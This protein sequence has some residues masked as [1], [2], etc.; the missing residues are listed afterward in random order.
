[1]P[2][3]QVPVPP[4]SHIATRQPAHVIAPNTTSCTCGSKGLASHVSIGA[5][6]VSVQNILSE[7]R[8]I[9]TGSLLA[10]DSRRVGCSGLCAGFGIG[11][12]NELRRNCPDQFPVGYI[13]ELTTMACERAIADADTT[14]QSGNIF[15]HC[16]GICVVSTPGME[17]RDRIVTKEGGIGRGCAFFIQAAY[18]GIC[19]LRI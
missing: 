5:M 17:M 12:R 10:S 15:C 2:L 1:M 8:R 3:I 7:L 19:R 14:C 4:S 9:N 16:H 13:P 11:E 6:P 18:I